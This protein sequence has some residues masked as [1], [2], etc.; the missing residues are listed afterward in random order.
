MASL[1]VKSIYYM[2]IA[3]PY[4]YR[5]LIML[6]FLTLLSY[7]DRVT[8]AL[9]SVRI[10]H[11]FHLTNAKFG[12]VLAAFALAY[13]LFEIPSGMLSDRI[14]QR[15]VF[16]RIVIWWSLFTALTGAATGILSLMFIRILFGMGESGTYPTSTGVISRWFPIKET[17]KSISALTMG[18]SVGAAIAPLLV[19]PIAAAYGWRIP[20]FVNGLLGLIWVLVCFSWFKDLPSNMKGISE[21]ELKLIETGRRFQRAHARIDWRLILKSRS[22]LA[23]SLMFFCSQCGNYFFIGWMPV[24]LQEA[25][26]F[27][28]NEM[29]LITSAVF[30]SGIAGAIFSW[31]ITDWLVKK[32]GLKNGRRLLGVTAMGMMA[33]LFAVT[34]FTSEKRIVV[35]SLISAHFFYLPVLISSFSSCVDMGGENAGTVTGIMNFAGQM[36]SFFLALYFGKIADITHSFELPMIILAVLLLS[37]ALLWLALDPEHQL[38]FKEKKQF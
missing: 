16:I 1:T 13:A 6:F 22:I 7:F 31:F 23:L 15:S 29:K 28:E 2:S 37:G 19:I 12:W 20:F 9:V 18:A 21:E 8:I 25:R 36:G 10:K 26:H 35:I 38:N 32:Y 24:Y 4:R 14:G 30:L 33:I 34:A 5:V 17:G 3:F 27:T 11:E